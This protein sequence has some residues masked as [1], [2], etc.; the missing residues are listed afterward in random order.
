MSIK[1]RVESG[2]EYLDHKEPGWYKKIKLEKLHMEEP[3]SCILGQL[4]GNFDEAVD[5]IYNMNTAAYVLGFHADADG[6]YNPDDS[7]YKKLTAAW[8]SEIKKRRTKKVKR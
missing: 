2:A 1:C 6:S 5:K 4:H 7:Y 3:N 8:K